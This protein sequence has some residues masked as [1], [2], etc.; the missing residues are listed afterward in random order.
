MPQ[1][2]PVTGSPDLVDMKVCGP[3]GFGIGLMGGANAEAGVVAAGAAAQ[4]SPGGGFFRNSTDGWSG[5]TFDSGGATAYAGSSST[6]TPAQT[7]TP[8]VGGLS[9]GGG[10]SLF[11]TN[12]GSVQQ[13]SGPFNTYSLNLGVG[14]LQ[15]SAQLATGGGIWQFSLSPPFAGA[16]FGFSGSKMVTS[17]ETSQGGCL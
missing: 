11:L 10:A 13:L 5:G 17:T 2:N 4:T 7:S 12:A 6:G 15:F 1:G 3:H 9:L 8:A 16:T 14:P